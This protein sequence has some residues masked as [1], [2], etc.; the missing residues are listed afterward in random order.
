MKGGGRG[1]DGEVVVVVT[2]VVA[3]ILSLSFSAMWMTDIL[4]V[5]ESL[6]APVSIFIACDEGS[7]CLIDIENHN[8][9]VSF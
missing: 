7:T 1:G 5:Y 2:N 6:N 9:T 8:R 3:D 4:T